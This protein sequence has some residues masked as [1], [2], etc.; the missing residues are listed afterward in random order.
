V[1][2]G[3]QDPINPPPHGQ[4]LAEMIPGTRLVEIP[5]MGHA[6]PTAVHRPLAEAILA[7]THQHP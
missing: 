2:Q 7:H 4:H 3:P 6:L 5:G 1:I